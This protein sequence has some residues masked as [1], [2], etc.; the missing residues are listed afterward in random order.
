MKK[1]GIALGGGAIFGAAHVGV[2]RAIEETDIDI[3]AISGTSIGALVAALYAFGKNWEDLQKIASEL[4]WMDITNLSPSKF[5][6]LS[7]QKIGEVIINHIGEQNIEDANIKLT[8]VAT[9][10]SNGKKIILDKGSVADAVMASTCLPGIF[11]PV[12]IDEKMLV[13]GGVVENLPI[14]TLKSMG[15]EYT[16]AVDLN[17]KHKYQEPTNILEVILNSFHFIMM[18]SSKHQTKQADLLIQPNLSEFNRLDMKQV[19]EL[20]KKGYDV[21]KAALKEL[22]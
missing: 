16:I 22:P 2:I 12:V 8:I 5:A 21:A 11:K 4:R 17:S 6:L 15:A 10:V 14:S 20:M 7:N 13:D 18:H 9:D 1:T 19:D 3:T